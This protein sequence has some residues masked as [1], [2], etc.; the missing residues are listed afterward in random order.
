MI[1]HKL[2]RI[3]QYNLTGNHHMSLSKSILLLVLLLIKIG[4]NILIGNSQISVC[5]CLTAK[6][7]ADTPMVIMYKS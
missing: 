1:V 5:L 3:A 7:G 4:H 2:A 6:A